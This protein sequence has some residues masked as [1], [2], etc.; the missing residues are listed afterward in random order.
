MKSILKLQ[1]LKSL[2]MWASKEAFIPSLG[3]FLG[4][5]LMTCGDPDPSLFPCQRFDYFSFQFFMYCD[6]WF[7]VF[8][9]HVFWILLKWWHFEVLVGNW[10]AAYRLINSLEWLDQILCC[11]IIEYTSVSIILYCCKNGWVYLWTL[12]YVS[13][14]IFFPFR[15]KIWVAMGWFSN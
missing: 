8:L 7:I 2:A 1:H 12:R 3:A 11:F 5:R 15:V 9:L 6:W 13:S 14:I 10:A 4:H